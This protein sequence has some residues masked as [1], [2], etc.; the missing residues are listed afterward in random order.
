MSSLT[1]SGTAASAVPEGA[2]TPAASAAIP[3]MPKSPSTAVQPGRAMDT[4]RRVGALDAAK[5]AVV[6]CGYMSRASAEPRA[7]VANAGYM[8]GESSSGGWPSG[9]RAAA[10]NIR[11]VPPSRSSTATT[12]PITAP[13]IAAPLAREITAG[14]RSPCRNVATASTANTAISTRS[15]RHPSGYS[16]QAL[17][18]ARIPTSCSAMYGIVARIPV[19]ATIRPRAAEPYRAFT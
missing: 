12:T 18:T 6:T 5:A 7:S 10:S 11:P 15:P 16:P 13:K 3:S 14:A 1:S 17:S 9:L 4:F 8:S 2:S 19:S